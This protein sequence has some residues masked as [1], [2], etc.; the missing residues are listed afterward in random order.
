MDRQELLRDI[1][2]I[3]EGS[4]RL[5]LGQLDEIK[6]LPYAFVENCGASGT[7]KGTLYTIYLMD[8]DGKKTDMEVCEVVV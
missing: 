8:T 5:S 7:G 2:E 6:E 4:K 1:E 3:T